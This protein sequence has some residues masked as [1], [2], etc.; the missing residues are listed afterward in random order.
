MGCAFMSDSDLQR[1]R[2][3]EYRRYRPR[4]A[5][6]TLYSVPCGILIVPGVINCLQPLFIERCNLYTAGRSASFSDTGTGFLVIL[7]ISS[8]ALVYLFMASQMRA[9]TRAE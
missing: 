2:V 3:L 6:E 7:V 1:L 8:Y 4:S 5:I 9:S